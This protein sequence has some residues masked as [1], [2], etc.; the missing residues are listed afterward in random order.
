MYETKLVTAPTA[1]PV[2]LAEVK[3]HANISIVEDDNYIENILIPAATE[4]AQAFQKRQLMPA[5]WR[6]TLRRFPASDSQPI[7][8]PLPPLVSLSSIT[9]QIASGAI[10]IISFGDYVV[11]VDGEPGY[12]IPIYG[13]S[14]P[15]TREYPTDVVAIEFVAGYGSTNAAALLA[16]PANTKLGILMLCAHWYLHREDGVAG[17]IVGHVKHAVDALLGQDRFE[18]SECDVEELEYA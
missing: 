1:Y 8:L 14:W 13:N 10:G 3:A 5:T 16:I 9:Y 12:V 7:Y 6:L 18:P 17:V 4:H 15:S 2:T 11:G